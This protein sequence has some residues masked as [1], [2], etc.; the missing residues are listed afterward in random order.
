VACYYML[1]VSDKEE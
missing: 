1:I